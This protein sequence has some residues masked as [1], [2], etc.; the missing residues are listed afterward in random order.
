MLS[1]NVNGNRRVLIFV[2]V[3]V[4]SLAA[5]LLVPPITQNQNY[6]DFADQRTILGIRIFG[7]S[8]PICRSLRS[9]SRVMAMPSRP[10]DRGAL[11]WN[12]DDRLRLGLLSR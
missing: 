11:P 4:A 6:H 8:Y 5:L 2:G 1:G 10:C 7:M 9:A 12:H 3:M